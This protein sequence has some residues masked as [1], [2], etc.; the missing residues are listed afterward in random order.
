MEPEDVSIDNA[1]NEEFVEILTLLTNC[2]SKSIALCN[3]TFGNSEPEFWACLQG[4][5]TIKELS[6]TNVTFSVISAKNLAEI[7]PKLTSLK[8]KG[9]KLG[10]RG[11]KALAPGTPSTLQ[12]LALVGVNMDNYGAQALGNSLPAAL[13]T[14]DVSE[15]PKLGPEGLWKLSPRFDTLEC[16]EEMN[17]A[18]NKLENDGAVHLGGHLPLLGRYLTA[19]DLSRNRIG[20]GGMESLSVGLKD[21]HLLQTL[22]LSGNNLMDAGAITLGNVL[23]HCEELVHLGLAKNSIGDDGCSGLVQALVAEMEGNEEESETNSWCKLQTL[24]LR[25]NNIGDSG[26][27]AWVE[28]LDTITSL[29]RLQLEGN[30]I[31]DARTRILEML[32]KHREFSMSSPPPA[33]RGGLQSPEPSDRDDSEAYSLQSGGIV[34]MEMVEAAREKL[35]NVEDGEIVRLHSDFFRHVLSSAMANNHKVSMN[36]GAF[37]KVYRVDVGGEEYWVTHLTISQVSPSIQNLR[38]SVVKELDDIRTD[39]VLVP[40]AVSLTKTSFCYIR[41]AD[42]LVPLRSILSSMEKRKLFKWSLRSKT[43]LGVVQALT[44]LHEGGESRKGMIHGNVNPNTIWID[45]STGKSQVVD[46]GLSRLLA[47]DREKFA[48]GDVVWGARGYR[49][50]RYERGS[51]SYTNSSDIFSLGI[52]AAELLT[53]ILQGTSFKDRMA[54]DIFYDIVLAGGNVVADQLAGHVHKPAMEAAGNAIVACCNPSP[55]KRPRAPTVEK[56]LEPFF[57]I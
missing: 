35:E 39:C 29:H 18:G 31:S 45:P 12:H 56:I 5:S 38:D 1:S 46:V 40:S 13:K 21:C 11:L 3:Q 49:C 57:S 24:D 22:D 43:L 48:P 26:A 23:L 44:F 17:L 55:M 19:L 33:R 20:A 27:G 10:P 28:G 42:D 14:L 47:T 25:D 2:A 15:N 16:L 53:G 8:V 50:V 32:L 54:S 37:G 9:C 7:F 6:L 4:M 34:N 51:C 52:V 30:D 36:N 41:P